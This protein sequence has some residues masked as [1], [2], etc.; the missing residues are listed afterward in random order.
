MNQ[1]TGQT[2][3]NKIV[4][5]LNDHDNILGGKT[6]S[7][8]YYTQKP[9]SIIFENST[10]DML[11]FFKYMDRVVTTFNYTRKYYGDGTSGILKIGNRI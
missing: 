1:K 6:V 8:Y 3:S 4:S 11:L 2:L 7:P 5:R 10:T 9:K